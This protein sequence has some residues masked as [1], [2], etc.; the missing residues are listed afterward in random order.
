MFNLIY[1]VCIWI[2]GGSCCIYI[3]IGLCCVC[4]MIVGNINY[5]IGWVVFVENEGFRN[6]WWGDLWWGF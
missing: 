6:L 2:I 4:E 3:Y 5:E 1:I